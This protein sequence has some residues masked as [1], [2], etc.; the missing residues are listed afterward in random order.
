MA[1]VNTE[2]EIVHLFFLMF[3]IKCCFSLASNTLQTYKRN[4]HKELKSHYTCKK[5]PIYAI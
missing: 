2:D 1:V 3:M 4:L 5:N